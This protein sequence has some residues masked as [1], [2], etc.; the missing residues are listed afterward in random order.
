MDEM[1]LSSLSKSMFLL[2]CSFIIDVVVVLILMAVTWFAIKA[3]RFLY[4]GIK[5]SWKEPEEEISDLLKM[6]HSR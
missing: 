3:G 6:K 5:K 4:V 2:I 1:I